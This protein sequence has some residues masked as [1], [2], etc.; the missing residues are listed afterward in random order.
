MTTIK[1]VA[2]RILPGWLF[3]RCV[4]ARRDHLIGRRR[5]S[6]AESGEDL[7]LASLMGER[8]K[9]GFYVDV[10]AHH[11]KRI[12]NTYYFYRRGWQ[13]INID[14]APGRKRLFDF[15]R[16]RDINLECGVA[17]QQGIMTYFMFDES[18]LNGF[19]RELSE[20][21]V[22]T[23]RFHLTGQKEALVV[24]LKQI[25]DE[26]LPAGLEID[27]LTVD[28]EG[29]DLEVLGSNDWSRYCPHFVLV[30]I[31]GAV[32][33]IQGNPIYSM[34]VQHGY[35]LQGKT[36]KTAIFALSGSRPI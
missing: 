36:L 5:V 20:D 29:M 35:Q 28:V 17:Q 2:A 18:E 3:T 31:K 7:L 24:S 15:Y 32:A 33:D 30:E 4:N 19:S 1:Q 6:Y 25:L 34:L 8:K 11:P 12:S 13:G 23:G 26:H 14:P 10:G 22:R 16:P 27:F 9:A 21:R